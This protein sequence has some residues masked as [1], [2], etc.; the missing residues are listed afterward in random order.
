M[1]G[2]CYHRSRTRPLR[3]RFEAKVDRSGGPDACHLWV[4][5]TDGHGYGQIK[6]QHPDG[7][8]EKAPRLALEW[9]LGRPLGPGLRALHNC[10]GGDNPA[11]V[12]ERHLWEGSQKDNMADCSAKGRLRF[13]RPG[14]ARGEANS[15]AVLTEADVIALRARPEGARILAREYGVSRTAIQDARSGKTWKHLGGARRSTASRGP[16]SDSASP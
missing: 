3:E 10:P 5:S 9:K 14:H 11:C 8:N 15:A 12:N 13:Q 4:G 16:V 6:R 7:R 1:I 2:A